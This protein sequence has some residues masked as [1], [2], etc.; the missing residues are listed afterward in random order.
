MAKGKL[1]EMFGQ[2]DDSQLRQFNQFVR[3]PFF[4]RHQQVI[5]LF[6]Y[7]R[8][9]KNGQF[10]SVTEEK[11]Y[12]RLFPAQPFDAAKLNHVKNYLVR[13]LETY[14]SWYTLQE[15]ELKQSREL[16]DG[17][18]HIGMDHLA[19]K[20]LRKSLKLLESS[21]L[22]DE[23]YYRNQYEIN[24]KDFELQIKSGKRDRDFN[25]QRLTD[26]L[27]IAYIA[28]KLKMAC[29]L[30]AHQ[31]IARK[32]YDT[33]LLDFL[34]TFLKDHPFLEEPT[35]RIYYHAYLSL[36]QPD[37]P[38]NLNLLIDSI[39]KY[40]H[41]FKV[42]D[43]R[44]I[45]LMA[46]NS[47]I[48]RSNKGQEE[49]LQPLFRL[50]RSGLESKVLLEN[51]M[52]TSWTY[53]N[54]ASAGLKLKEYEWVFDFIHDYKDYLPFSEQEPFFHFNLA[55]YYFEQ[56]EFDKAMPLLS[57][58][59]YADLL[60]NLA[61][62]MMLTKMYYEEGEFEALSSLLASIKK[63]I[64]RKKVLGYHKDHYLAIIAYIYKMLDMPTTDRAAWRALR[65]EIAL[66][67]VTE[68]DW[69]LEQIDRAVA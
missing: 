24:L 18:V 54:A 62:K 23:A 10:V 25:L 43:L 69:L 49:Y 11:M 13:V 61:A 47:C 36:T 16:A 28:E 30:L 8:K 44:N 26:S 5:Q 41:L 46:I 63:F 51:G 59:E 68:K 45:Y 56:K 7:L 39:Y 19:Q 64:Y 9:H 53:K 22:R 65:N 66:S 20:Q 12:A 35:I 15:S 2:L 3:S 6:E 67:K 1:I 27:D 33:G 57:R 42:A 34:N 21:D 17:L 60:T 38:E 32:E 40:S 50:Y 55:K 14:L 37:V 29:I 52:L 58:E 48:R 31:T 4:N